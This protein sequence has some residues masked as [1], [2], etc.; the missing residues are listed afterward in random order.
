M[1]RHLRARAGLD[2]RH[3]LTHWAGCGEGGDRTSGVRGQAA[4]ELCTASGSIGGPRDWALMTGGAAGG[5]R[6]KGTHNE[7]AEVA[8]NK[9][10]PR[11]ACSNANEDR[12]GTRHPGAAIEVRVGAATG[13]ALEPVWTCEQGCPEL[14]KEAEGRN[15]QREPRPAAGP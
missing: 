15:G 8:V 1:R 3:R 4:A 11:G 7:E 14:L 5:D 12:P 9:V 10:S 2:Y 13:A 6:G